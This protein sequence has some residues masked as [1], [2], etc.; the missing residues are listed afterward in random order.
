M[1]PNTIFK[2][3]IIQIR[4]GSNNANQWI[5]TDDRDLVGITYTP[6]FDDAKRYHIKEGYRVSQLTGDR[7][8]KDY[9]D[10]RKK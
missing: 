7:D 2:T 4:A 9:R 8:P 10:Y 3:Y 6:N 1:T 5:K